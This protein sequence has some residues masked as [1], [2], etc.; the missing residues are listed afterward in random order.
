MMVKVAEPIYVCCLFTIKNVY[1]KYLRPPRITIS[2]NYKLNLLITA[3]LL[4]IEKLLSFNKTKRK[5]KNS[6]RYVPWK[7][8]AE[9]VQIGN[10]KKAWINSYGTK[11]FSIL[12]E[13]IF[14]VTFCH[15]EKKDLLWDNQIAKLNI[16]KSIQNIRKERKK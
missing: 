15:A 11:Y 12:K 3:N 5:V 8:L 9:I 2:Q 16:P 10:E 14:F 4:L 7:L 1:C 6:S 13:Y